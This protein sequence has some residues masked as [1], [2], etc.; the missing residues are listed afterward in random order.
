MSRVSHTSD[1]AASIRLARAVS[2]LQQAGK[3]LSAATQAAP[4][5]YHQKQLRSLAVDL[6][7]LSMPITGIATSLERGGRE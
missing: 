4:D 3:E 5:R 6:R 2:H 1:C 7:T